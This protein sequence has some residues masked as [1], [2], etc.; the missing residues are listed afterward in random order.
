M[1]HD[2]KSRRI[3]VPS[4]FRWIGQLSRLTVRLANI[5]R[6]K[7]SKNI[8]LQL[9]FAFFLSLVGAV[10]VFFT[11]NVFLGELNRAPILDY[12]DGIEAIDQHARQMALSIK[13]KQTTREQLA[14]QLAEMDSDLYEVLL[15]D[16]NGNVLVKSPDA[17]E[18]KVDVH[19]LIS[20]AMDSR[21]VI[22]N[23][24]EA[25]TS[26]YPVRL[27]W[28]D[29]YL[30]VT[31]VPQP[32]IL[33]RR[34]SSPLA[35]FI[36]IGAF[37]AIFY[38]LTKGKM[39]FLQQ[40]AKGVQEI[41]KGNLDYRIPIKGRDEMGM[42]AE[43][44]NRMAEALQKTIEEERRAERT[45]NELITNIS[46]DLRTP[47]T[48]VMGYLQL[49]KDKPGLSEEQAAHYLNIAYS[50]SEKL[51]ALIDDL[52]EYTKLSNQLAELNREPVNL[53]DL[54]EQLSEEM[55]TYAEQQ[56]IAIIKQFPPDKIIVSIDPHHMIR[57]YENLLTNAIKYSYKPGSIHIRLTADEQKVTTCITNYGDPIPQSQ[58]E[59]LFDRFYRMDSSRSSENGGSGLGLAIAKS[60]IEGHG[61]RIWP[62]AEGNQIRFYVE[63][64]LD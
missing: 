36:A 30:V 1:N 15:V 13:E 60:I 54:L 63:L 18:T 53:P 62:E 37:L 25:F 40:L 20:N 2:T 32:T 64:K 44:I 10:A 22:D 3:A 43:N 8:R 47:L 52:F 16:L 38:W 19:N 45:K 4:P 33:Y 41:A 6:M 11:G 42:L 61:G 26:V 57:A 27:S 56:D 29:G 9:I 7:V 14:A 31:G 35:L 51:K 34:G 46:H 39:D 48:L 58:L 49:L 59:R 17:T 5:S 23:R 12:T 50:K 55:V 28:M 24:V 21:Y